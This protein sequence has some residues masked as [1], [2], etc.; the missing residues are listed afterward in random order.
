MEQ[1]GCSYPP[2]PNESIA[3]DD[4]DD[5]MLVMMKIVVK[6]RMLILAPK[7]YKNIHSK[8]SVTDHL[9]IAT[10]HLHRS[11]YLGFKQ[12]HCNNVVTP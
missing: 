11:L 9:H 7:P 3:D 6:M 12:Y 4:D 8:T 2:C 1:T 5:M 10:T